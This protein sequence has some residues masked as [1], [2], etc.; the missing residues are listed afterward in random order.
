MERTWEQF[1]SALERKIGKQ[2]M[3]I[4]IRA[5]R[6]E[7][8]HEDRVRMRV[9]N[10]H[11]HDWIRDNLMPDIRLAWAEILGQPIQVEML[12]EGAAAQPEA[13]PV[14]VRK[15]ST[16]LDRNMTFESFVVGKCNEFAHAASIA[17]ADAPGR[18]HNPLFIY[19]GT[20][21]GKTHLAHAIGN[22][23][24]GRTGGGVFY[25]TAE[26]FFNAMV[27]AL[28]NRAIAEFRD[29]F[30]TEVDLLILDDVQF[31]AGRDRTEEELFHVFEAMRAEGKQIVLTADEPPRSI[32]KLE[33]RLR[34]R[35]EG[36]LLADVQPPDVETMMA[37]LGSKA[38]TMRLEIPS[39]VQYNIASRVR[40]SVREL[41]GVLN[42]LSALQAFYGSPITMSFIQERMSD[43]VPPPA[44]PPT[45]DQIIQRVAEHYSVRPADIRGN[46]RPANI[47]WPRQ[48]AMYLTRRV[49]NLS[50][51]EIGREFNRDNST[52][53]HGVKKVEEE[54]RK[55][56]NVRAELEMLEKLFRNG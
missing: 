31:L 20:G 21:L 44:P 37:I 55:N 38:A 12:L 34:T 35:F 18:S 54:A 47:A 24:A 14:H 50:F 51:P 22:R 46:R 33:P 28:Q 17:V 32:G 49:T 48:I 36:G 45:A 10:K 7:A 11:Y 1:C 29:R 2:D 27:R 52:V 19:G 3:E 56:P 39:D 43:I 4:W 6:P 30:R 15:A 13:P 25:C 23:V 40:N 16:H 42:R 5:L 26:Q 41:E 53:Q 8:V 9:E